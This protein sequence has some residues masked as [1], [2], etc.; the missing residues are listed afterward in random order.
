MKRRTE[1]ARLRRQLAEA[2]HEARRSR[3]EAARQRERSDLAVGI[4]VELRDRCQQMAFESD[5]LA[6]EAVKK[7]ARL[8]DLMLAD[9]ILPSL[10]DVADLAVPS[11]PMSTAL[12]FCDIPG[13][14]DV[15]LILAEKAAER[16]S[17]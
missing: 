9:R 4:A 17:A 15:S 5:N 14:T 11:W 3:K 6:A 2:K 12:I 13:A 8:I 10:D 16:M 1:L 7:D